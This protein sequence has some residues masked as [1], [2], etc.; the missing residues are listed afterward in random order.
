MRT[1]TEI[2]NLGRIMTEQWWTQGA[3]RNRNTNDWF[4]D[5][6]EDLRRDRAVVVCMRCPV[7]RQ[8][9][10][11]AVTAPE[12]W[13]IWGATTSRQRAGARAEDV[14]VL[15]TLT[16]IAAVERG[17]IPKRPTGTALSS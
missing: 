17:L 9:V 4:A 3:C 14:D 15:M 11:W 10:E 12:K 16:R 5:R 1:T 13:G 6:G 2:F 8:C 7:R